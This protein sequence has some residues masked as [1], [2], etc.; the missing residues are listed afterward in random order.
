EGGHAHAEALRAPC[1]QRADASQADDAEPC[2]VELAPEE[3]AV[4]AAGAHQPVGARHA[5]GGGEHQRQRQLGRGDVV[6][7]RSVHHEDP[8]TTRGL[9]I[10]VVDPYA[11]PSDDPEPGRLG[12]Q[13]LVDLSATAGDDRVVV[14]DD[15]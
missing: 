6:R 11:A 10:D 1:H 8:A 2:A 5:A 12:E 7:L 3:A 14:A 13:L 4:P 9:E 15:A